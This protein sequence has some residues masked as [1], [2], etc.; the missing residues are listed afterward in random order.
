MKS[1]QSVKACRDESAALD[2]I[3]SAISDYAR[4]YCQTTRKQAQNIADAT[5]NDL[6]IN[7]A[8]FGSLR[9]AQRKRSPLKMRSIIK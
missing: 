7:V 3:R 2:A 8:V 5:L 4:E 9:Y 1:N 6:Q